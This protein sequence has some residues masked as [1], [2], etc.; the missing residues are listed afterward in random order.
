MSTAFVQTP[1]WVLTHPD[2]DGS[3]VRVF[4]VLQ[5]HSRPGRQIFPGITRLAE[6][7]NM[8]RSC[9]VRCL[10][11]LE[12]IGAIRRHR[13]LRGGRMATNLYEVAFDAPFGPDPGVEVDHAR[14]PR[15]DHARIPRGE[16]EEGDLHEAVSAPATASPSPGGVRREDDPVTATVVSGAKQSRAART[17]K[18]RPADERPPKAPRAPKERDEVFDEVEAELR[19]RGIDAPPGGLVQEIA[20]R[21]RSTKRPPRFVA[22]LAMRMARAERVN[23]ACC[24]FRERSRVL[25]AVTQ[26]AGV[27]GDMQEIAR[28]ATLARAAGERSV[29]MALS[30]RWGRYEHAVAEPRT[31]AT[32]TERSVAHLAEELAST[33]TIRSLRDRLTGRSSTPALAATQRCIDVASVEAVHG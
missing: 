4:G 25:G 10:R 22:E 14:N 15:V 13:R 27:C 16:A 26:V 18:T 11:D 12:A 29:A 32:R 20:K 5:S 30:E 24:T 31:D 23:L 33:G 2:L 1:I 7:A 17:A 8:G 28:R 21:A 6:M 3:A 9:L 19:A